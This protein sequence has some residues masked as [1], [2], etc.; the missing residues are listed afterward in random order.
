MSYLILFNVCSTFYVFIYHD[1]RDTIINH[2]DLKS[3]KEI[4]S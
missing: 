4:Q 3:S 1:Y 2:P